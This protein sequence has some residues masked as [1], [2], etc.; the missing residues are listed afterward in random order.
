MAC[1][2]CCSMSCD[3]LPHQLSARRY[4]NVNQNLREIHLKINSEHIYYIKYGCNGGKTYMSLR[5]KVIDSAHVLAQ[6]AH[7]LL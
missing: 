4:F 7:V 2:S 1:S 5:S 3:S 6:L